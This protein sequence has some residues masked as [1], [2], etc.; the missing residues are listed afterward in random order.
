MNSY[1]LKLPDIESYLTNRVPLTRRISLGYAIIA[2]IASVIILVM[3]FAFMNYKA[4]IEAISH[5]HRDIEGHMTI[6]ANMSEMQRQARVYI[7]EGHESARIRVQELNEE[8][9]ISLSHLTELDA[10][11]LKD[12]SKR[13]G[14]LLKEYISSFDEMTRY[15]DQKDNALHVDFV[16]SANQTQ[17]KLQIL[18]GQKAYVP[19]FASMKNELLQV[20]KEAY[21]Y[22]NSLD[23]QHVTEASKHFQRVRLILNTHSSSHNS[24][25]KQALKHF[26]DELNRYESDFYTGVQLTRGYLFLVNVVLAADAYEIDYLA[27]QLSKL[28][29][30]ESTAIA[31]RVNHQ[32]NA[33]FL[34]ISLTGAVLLLIAFSVSYKV[35]RSIAMPLSR[36]TEVFDAL[37]VGKMDTE[38]PHYRLDDELGKLSRAAENFRRRSVELDE[39]KKQLERSNE[40]M[41]QFVFT[42]SHDL[43]SPIVTSNGFISI[44]N[45]LASQ[46]KYPEAMNML[47]KVVKANDRMSQLIT[48]LLQLSRVGRVEM[49]SAPVDLNTLLT[50]FSALNQERLSSHGFKL[51]VPNNLPEVFANR[52]RL[53]QLFENLISNALKY[54]INPAGSLIEVGSQALPEAQLVYVKDNGPG[55]PPDYHDKIFGLFYRLDLSSE[56]TGVGLAVAKKIMKYY[57]GDIWVE[58]SPGEGATFWMKFP[59]TEL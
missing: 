9:L 11:D 20:E 44:I 50:E 3:I 17:E 53:M 19:A 38:I 24:S 23:Y 26:M 28:S 54:A 51:I 31:T 5:L 49:E 40:E 8:L 22:F 52:S 35:G 7:Y 58:S 12:K 32:I 34:T 18:L 10:G 47:S 46:G 56:G 42:V 2:T 21:R 55:I 6:V 36:L 45:K 43:K 1:W 27:N 30:D 25:Q 29:K 41:E 59:I 37:S 14:A 13:I 33:A 15:R 16:N 48:D 57:G 39:S 4:N